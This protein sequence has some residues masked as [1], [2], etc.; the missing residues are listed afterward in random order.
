MIALSINWH[1]EDQAWLLVAQNRR[2]LPFGIGGS[3]LVAGGALLALSAPMA[4]RVASWA[5]VNPHDPTP[6]LRPPAW[7]DAVVAAAI[8]GAALLLALLSRWTER[9]GL[10]TMLEMRSE[11]GREPLV[12][13]VSVTLG[14]DRATIRGA[15]WEASYDAALLTGIE[16][17]PG[18]LILRFGAAR[19]VM[20]PR[21]D[22]T[23]PD[24]AAVRDWAAGVLGHDDAAP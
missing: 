19:P 21:R 12:G 17:P 23:E 20:L 5:A 7:D 2:G 1:A 16:E 3:Q 11:E 4:G 22:L 18:Y 13:P 24:A 14:P 8:L 10:R 6:L 9:L 15:T